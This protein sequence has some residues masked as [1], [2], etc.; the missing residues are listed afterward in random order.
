MHSTA[1]VATTPR[2][3]CGWETGTARLEASLLQTVQCA[4]DG[5]GH[6]EE[7]LADGTRELQRQA[8]ERAAQAKADATPPHCPVCGHKLTRRQRDHTRSAGGYPGPV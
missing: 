1:T 2:F 7:R 4:T 5:L 3:V 8:L 6:L